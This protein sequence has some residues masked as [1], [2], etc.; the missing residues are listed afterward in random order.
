V[1]NVANVAEVAEEQN[2]ERKVQK[3]EQSNVEG[4]AK[5]VAAHAE[6]SAVKF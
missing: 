2:A 3:L 4:G 5:A 1:E 6:E